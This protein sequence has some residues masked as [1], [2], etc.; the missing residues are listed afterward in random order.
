MKSSIAVVGDAFI[1]DFRPV[2]KKNDTSEK[3]GVPVYELEPSYNKLRTH[4]P[5]GAAFLAALLVPSSNTALVS[6]PAHS[7]SPIAQILSTLRT[8]AEAPPDLLLLQANERQ[9]RI[10]GFYSRDLQNRWGLASRYDELYDVPPHHPIDFPKK[11]FDYLI[12][13]DHSRGALSPSLLNDLQS[14]RPNRIIISAQH[15]RANL[16]Q[17]LHP[18]PENTVVVCTDRQALLWTGIDSP[19]TRF[20]QGTPE[21]PPSLFCRI[22]FGI[23]RKG[24]R[25][26]SSHT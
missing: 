1:E 11:D 21:D 25:L 19:P 2:R 5:G 10:Q 20:P 6:V 14:L 17:Q 23:D 24:T 13:D 8:A 15:D 18:N 4:S 3:T 12:L 16:Y 9:S 26:N 7:S 22:F